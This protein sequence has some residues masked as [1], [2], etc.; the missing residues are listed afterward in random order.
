MRSERNAVVDHYGRQPL[1]LVGHFHVTK[2]LITA[3]KNPLFIS[4]MVLVYLR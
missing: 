3:L 4:T 1:R 2:F